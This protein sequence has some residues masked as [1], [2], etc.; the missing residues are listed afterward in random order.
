MSNKQS[1]KTRVEKVGKKNDT[2][3]TNQI[4]MSKAKAGAASEEDAAGNK[5][6]GGPKDKTT[7]SSANETTAKKHNATEPTTDVPSG[8][9]KTNPNDNPIEK[10]GP[11][12]RRDSKVAAGPQQSAGPQAKATNTTLAAKEPAEEA[13]VKTA[14]KKPVVP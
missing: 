5:N 10:E 4:K 12:K 2:K 7:G 1:K 9:G 3:D 8:R 14:P 6:D 13:A 11:A